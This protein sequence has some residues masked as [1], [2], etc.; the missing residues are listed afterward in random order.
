MMANIKRYA[1]VMVI[2]TTALGMGCS[3]MDHTS[4]P[5][6]YDSITHVGHYASLAQGEYEGFYA[7]TN[8]PGIGDHGLGTFDGLDGEMIVVDGVV[9]HA[10]LDG[11][12]SEA[13]DRSSVAA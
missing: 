12:L 8:L 4:R 7:V 9:Y 3:T 2:V 6:V 11:V 5:E 1:A 13:G 10:A